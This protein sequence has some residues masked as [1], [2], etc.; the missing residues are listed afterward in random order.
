MVKSRFPNVLSRGRA[1]GK[2]LRKKTRTLRQTKGKIKKKHATIKPKDIYSH[3]RF[4]SISQRKYERALLHDLH[5]HRTRSSSEQKTLLILSITDVMPSQK[6]YRF[7]YV[8]Q[9][10]PTFLLIINHLCKCT[11]HTR[12]A[13]FCLVNIFKI[14]YFLFKYSYIHIKSSA[15]HFSF[16]K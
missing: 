16:S 4:P 3:T 12:G 9:T 11:V 8:F 2:R 5:V 7:F 13:S 15:C 6:K 10:N 14:K 1:K